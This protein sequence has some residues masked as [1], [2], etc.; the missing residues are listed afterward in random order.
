MADDLIN[1]RAV[2][3]ILENMIFQSGKDLS[4]SYLLQ[5][6]KERVNRIQTAF[7]LEKV[8]EDL[9]DWR[10]DAEKWAAKYDKIGDVDNMEI[11][12]M[13]ARSYN[14]AIRI[15]EKGGIE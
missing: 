13:A 5:D 4:K 2:V 15:I 9:A 1:R 10:N 14:N 11:Q 8:I 6:A 12:D 3:D 7:D